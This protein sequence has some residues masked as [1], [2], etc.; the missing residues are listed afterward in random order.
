M[1]PPRIGLTHLPSPAS[2]FNLIPKHVLLSL[3]RLSATPSS[4]SKPFHTNPPRP[5]GHNRWSKIKHDKARADS[6]RSKAR[7][8]LTRDLALASRTHGAD[9]SSNPKLASLIASAKKIG[10]SKSSTEA[11]I[12][13]GQGRSS[14]GLRLEPFTMELLHTA[15]GAA[16]LVECMTDN[17]ARTLQ[18]VR[19]AVKGLGVGEGSVEWMFERRGRV[20]LGRLEG[21]MEGGVEEGLG[22]EEVMEAAVE[23]GAV[24]AEVLD[25]V[26]EVFTEP[27]ELGAV[28]ESV[29][30]KLGRRVE[31]AELV[32]V[33]KGEVEVE[34]DGGSKEGVGLGKALERVEELDSVV[35]VWM[36]TK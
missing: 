13:R 34:V 27:E 33:A 36:N 14:S 26:A 30:G 10:F 28:A 2:G 29:A 35:A 19:E 6:H 11:A 22:E 8:Q 31:R 3:P 17:K 32:W 21:D 7:T 9:P 1:P 16:M 25:G 15:T 23:A 5:S 18:E 24:D 20:V 4:P 12:A